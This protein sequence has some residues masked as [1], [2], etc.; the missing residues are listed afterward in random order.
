MIDKVAFVFDV[1]HAGGIEATQGGFFRDG[2][3]FQL[4]PIVLVV[5]VAGRPLGTI[6]GWRWKVILAAT[7]L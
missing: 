2:P 1:F 7:Y 4:V 6:R 5:L 3:S